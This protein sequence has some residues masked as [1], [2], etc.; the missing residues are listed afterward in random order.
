MS[1]AAENKTQISEYAAPTTLAE[2]VELI[3][4]CDATILAGG[5]DL[6]VQIENGRRQYGSR[7]VNIRR[8]EEM[9]GIN[10]EGDEVRIGALTTV[11]DILNSDLLADI[12]PV[13]P[14]TA[15]CFASGQLRNMATLG[16]NICNASPAG[17]MIIPLILLDAQVVLSAWQDCVVAQRLVP[18]ADF[19]TGPSKTVMVEYEI[20]SEIRFAK[21][22]AGYQARFRKSGPRPALEISTVSAGVG[23]VHGAG[24]MTDVRVALGAVAPVPYRAKKTE[25]YL[26]GKTM[27]ADV[28][29]EAAAIAADEVNPIDDVRASAWYRKHLT[30]VFIKRL[31]SDDD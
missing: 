17:D 5:T 29:A 9:C 18:I 2:A 23:A 24:G 26:E 12:A 11:T 21:P 16:G 4:D 7:L 13:L 28:A 10:V 8:V 6:M 22:P 30:S 14:Q 19:F 20:L 1:Q 15:D 3:A 25:A 27:S 31:L